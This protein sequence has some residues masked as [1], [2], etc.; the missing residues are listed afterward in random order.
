MKYP[1][2][3]LVILLL[4]PLFV[5]ACSPTREEGIQLLDTQEEMQK[6]VSRYI[7]L[8]IPIQK[9]RQIM[10]D[11]KFSCEDKKDTEFSVEKR[12]KNGHPLG[13]QTIVRGDFL[14]CWI[15]RSYFIAST[16]WGVSLLYK[17][18]RVVMVY[19]VINY[20]NL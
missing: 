19:A 3:Q 1:A 17:N 12:D 10:E 18:N 6:E 2:K 15:T 14:S 4:L 13:S 5:L 11:N 8:G 7:S 16:T 9:A 20:Q